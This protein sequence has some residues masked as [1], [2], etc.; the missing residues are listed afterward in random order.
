MEAEGATVSPLHPTDSFES[1]REGNVPDGKRSN[2][3]KEHE[4]PGEHKL[5]IRKWEVNAYRQ[6]RK[7]DESKLRPRTLNDG[8]SN[9]SHNDEIVNGESIPI[10]SAIV[11]E[12]IYLRW[13][14]RG[15]C[16]NCEHI[17]DGSP[18][19]TV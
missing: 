10:Y 1:K 5:S 17:K 7:Y 8:T 14:V 6:S 15:N 12:D 18:A 13:S 16:C 3:E 9:A 4:K 2:R 19:S 11:P